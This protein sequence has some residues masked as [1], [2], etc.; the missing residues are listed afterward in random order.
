MEY[1][2]VA[3]EDLLFGNI[4]VAEYPTMVKVM[5]EADIQITA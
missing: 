2:D 1:Y 3:K 5:E 4:T